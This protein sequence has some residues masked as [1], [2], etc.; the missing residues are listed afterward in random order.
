VKT[1]S[2]ARGRQARLAGS[3]ALL[4]LAQQLLHR[5]W[6]LAHHVRYL[7]SDSRRFGGGGLGQLHC[8]DFAGRVETDRA[9]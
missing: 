1:K 6:Q 9:R 4:G 7:V 3:R 8:D 5:L 2:V